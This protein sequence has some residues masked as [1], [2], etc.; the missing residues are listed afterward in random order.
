MSNSHSILRILQLQKQ[1]PIFILDG[2]NEILGVSQEFT[3]ITGFK[4]K[5]IRLRKIFSLLSK[6]SVRGF[7]QLTKEC[8]SKKIVSGEFGLI[9]AGTI[10]QAARITLFENEKSGPIIGLV[11]VVDNV[12][13]L[14][15]EI[16]AVNSIADRNLKKLIKSNE[17]L[18]NARKAE[19]E[20]LNVKEKFLTN[21]SHELRTPLAGISGITQ[22]LSNT[23][24]DTMQQEYVGSILHST[25]HL[26]RMIN[27]LL[28][29]SKLKSEKFEL[30]LQE[31]SLYECLK[32]L[33]SSFSIICEK[34]NITFNFSY[35]KNIPPILIG[36]SLRISQVVN[37]LL[38]NAYKFTEHGY[39]YL[40]VQLKKT[41]KNLVNINFEITDTGIGIEKGN[42]KSIFDEF[43]QAG[44]DTARLYGGTG[45]GLSISQ[46]LVRLQKGEIFVKSKPGEG[47]TFYFTLPLQIGEKI[48]KFNPTTTER[49]EGTRVLIAD[50]N[51]VNIL[52][53]E[54][55]LKK[56]GA[57]VI[58]SS[59]GSEA[60]D[61][62]KRN[63][64][65]LIILDLN[66]P[67][68]DGYQLC[69]TFRKKEKKKIPIIA[70]TAG[71][72][73]LVEK[74]CREAGFTSVIYKPFTSEEFVAELLKY[75]SSKK[76]FS[77]T[78]VQIPESKRQPQST[79]PD[80]SILESVSQG[81]TDVY[82]DLIKTVNENIKTEIP[83]LKIA[84][85]K[86]QKKQTAHILHKIK[87]SYGYIGMKLE[88]E[89]INSAEL[90]L[91]KK[92]SMI[93]I[94]EKLQPVFDKHGDLLKTLDNKLN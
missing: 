62:F 90:L 31:F 78:A 13:Q 29:L 24:L 22:L 58:S 52:V 94:T 18:Q 82:L 47:S 25:E 1:L 11:T 81:K 83:L 86:K 63:S 74:R 57:N 76:R 33:A 79:E 51:R 27:E 14:K 42:L 32:N 3:K 55:I 75:L 41:T 69:A 44:S 87:T 66:M 19:Q 20:A 56:E 59:N 88:V 28:D 2:R 23:K 85:K 37:N 84:L 15:A 70:V 54:N 8:R 36:D 43:Q 34:K 17:K 39:I 65:D 93:K 46:Y 80:F 89:L 7:H 6:G 10:P 60:L 72:S 48:K 40:N 67:K 61:H 4:L 92:V 38:S 21:I 9:N 73:Q 16:D 50:D 30:E 26:V 91:E 45:L 71:S 68:I 12:G 53:I 64:F 49:L 5:D 35:D 77:S